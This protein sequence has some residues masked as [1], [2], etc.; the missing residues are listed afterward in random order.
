LEAADAERERLGKQ[1]RTSEA[2]LAEA[3]RVA[4]LVCKLPVEGGNPLEPLSEK[5]WPDQV[6]ITRRLYAAVMDR[7]EGKPPKRRRRKKVAKMVEISG[8]GR[9]RAEA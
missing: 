6:M 8:S 4:N 7:A 5:E 9:R 2:R 1:L 3:Q